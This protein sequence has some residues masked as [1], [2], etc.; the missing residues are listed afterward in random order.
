M[1]AQVWSDN[2]ALAKQATVDQGGEQA[3]AAAAR[4]LSEIEKA[5]MH[6]A[7]DRS[8]LAASCAKVRCAQ[9]A[10]QVDVRIQDRLFFWYPARHSSQG[11]P[12]SRKRFWQSAGRV[13]HETQ[14]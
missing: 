10:G 6:R 8:F 2:T 12:I 14:A 7:K 5:D 4:V 11:L 9:D 13:F 1:L 3:F